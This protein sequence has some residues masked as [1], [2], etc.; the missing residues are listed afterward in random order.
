MVFLETNKRKAI[1]AIKAIIINISLKNK[2]E[3]KNNIAIILKATITLI[4]KKIIIDDLGSRNY[5]T[6]SI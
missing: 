6:L 2:R 4:L 1:K 5:I 3:I